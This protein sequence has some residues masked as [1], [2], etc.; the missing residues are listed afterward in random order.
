MPAWLDNDPTVVTTVNASVLE[1]DANHPV[2]IKDGVATA[3]LEHP[4]LTWMSKFVPLQAQSKACVTVYIKLHDDFK[5]GDGGKL[6]GF[7]NTGQGHRR[8][9][10]DTSTA[11]NIRI[12][13]GRRMAS[14]GWRAPAMADGPTAASASIPIFTRIRWMG[15]FAA[16][17]RWVR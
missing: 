3:S 5:P 11:R 17:N 8:E 1:S 12:P 4:K 14:I 10:P 2:T 9:G 13:P 6:P 16:P 7:A 15:I